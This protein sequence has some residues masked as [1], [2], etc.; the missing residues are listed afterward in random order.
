MP[1][2]TS[3]LN[4]VREIFDAVEAA[5]YVVLQPVSDDEISH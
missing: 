2:R 1:D 5:L 4:P 3:G